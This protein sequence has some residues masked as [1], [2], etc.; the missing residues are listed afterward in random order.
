MD[1]VYKARN[2]QLDRIQSGGIALSIFGTGKDIL[3]RTLIS[4]TLRTTINKRNLIEMKIFCKAKD[5]II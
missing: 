5:A 3:N 1:R 4:H 2:T